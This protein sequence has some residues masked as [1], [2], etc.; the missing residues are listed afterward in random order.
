MERSNW[1]IGL[2]RAENEKR[3]DGKFVDVE[4]I[5]P[6]SIQFKSG[7]NDYFQNYRF[8]NGNK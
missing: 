5:K 1:M 8:R 6:F 4:V 2:L 3:K 7:V